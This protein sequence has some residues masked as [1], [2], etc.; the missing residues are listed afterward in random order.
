MLIVKNA[1][2]LVQVC[3]AGERA[4]TGEAMSRVAV[5]E[6]GF[7]AVD[8]DGVIQFV[9]TEPEFRTRFPDLDEATC[10]VLDATGKVVMPGLVDCHT[11]PVH[12]GD[13]VG[14]FAMKLK[15]AT[16]M[17]IH[18][19]GGGIGFTVRH[20]EAATEAELAAG[21]RARFDR[22]LAL[23]TTTVEAK[24][25]YGLKR[26]TE[27]KML[28]ALNTV[29]GEHPLTILRTF[30]G[31]HSIHPDFEG[32]AERATLHQIETIPLLADAGGCDMVDVFCEKGIFS[33]DQT[34]RI[35]R[36]GQEHGYGANFH[37]DELSCTHSG[38]LAGEIGA[39]SM[40]HCELTS[41]EGMA[42]MA[43]RGVVAVVLPTTSYIL[44]IDPAP[45]RKFIDAGVPVAVASDTNPNAPCYNMPL[46][47]HLACV[48]CHLSM[49]EALV[50]ATLNAAAAIGVSDR[51]GSLEEG[52]KGDFLVLSC[53]RWE[54]II[55]AL[56]DP[57]I[58]TV[59]KGGRRV[60]KQ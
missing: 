8:D 5:I 27:L 46:T 35:L 21:A 34:R 9:G 51:V 48:F 53:P 20:V 38:E 41:D 36:A 18:K 14:E 19:A 43:K 39:L 15:G 37:G 10:R 49:E 60:A 2:Q 44:R 12:A 17:D 24:T 45:A 31:A 30:L 42:A 54:H 57:P 26:D 7:M 11:H 3:A 16:Y 13:R 22:M 40:S 59:W 50:A 25:G 47:M 28:R 56:G 6:N 32:D 4:L 33:I 52:K 23:G 55:Y 29:R 1:A 58:E